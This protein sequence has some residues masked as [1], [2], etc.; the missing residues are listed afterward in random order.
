[1][2]KCTIKN[3][4]TPLQKNKNN[5]RRKKEKTKQKINKKKNISLRPGAVAL[6]NPEVKIAV[7]HVCAPAPWL[8]NR[9]S[10]SKQK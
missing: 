7:S 4:S 8:G 5:K 10:V 6:V 1:M 3:I 2:T 9:D